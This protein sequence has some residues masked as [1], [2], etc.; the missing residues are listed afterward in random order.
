MKIN[1]KNTNFEL[2]EE[3]RNYIDARLVKL[4]KYLNGNEDNMLAVE[5]ERARGQN[6]G[7][8]FRVE[9]LLNIVGRKSLRA[10]AE[11]KTWRDAFHGTLDK[12]RRELRDL[13]GKER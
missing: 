12:A 8:I 6:S 2:T 13:K 9:F 10:E 5:I 7:N 4:D 11:G 3:V 1:I